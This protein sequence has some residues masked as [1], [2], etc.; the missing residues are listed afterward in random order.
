MKYDFTTVA[1]RRNIGAGKWEL[2]LEKNPNAAEGVIP[3]SV[4][5]MEFY[6]A[7]ELMNGLAKYAMQPIYGYTSP[8]DTYYNAVIDYMKKYHNWEIQ[9]EWICPT[10]GVVGALNDLVRTLTEPGDGVVIMRPVYYP[11]SSAITRNNR[12]LVNVPLINNNGRYEIDF[13]AFDQAT[14]PEEVKMFILCSPHN[15][16]GRVW[17]KDELRKMGDICVKNNIIIIS[18]EIHFDFIM[19]KHEHTVIST[20]SEEI[21]KRT[22]VCTAPSKTFNLG[23]VKVSNIIIQ[24]PEYREKYVA[25]THSLNTFAYKTCEIVYTECRNWFEELMEVLHENKKLVEDFI[26]EHLPMIKVYPLEGTY[27]MWLD[28]RALGLSN[29]EL[30]KLMLKHDL[31]LDEGYLFGEEGSGFERWNI[32]CPKQELLAGL[33]RFKAA[34]ETL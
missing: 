14:K 2:M 28:C 32:A 10:S 12:N 11:F 18:D 29:E 24:N 23:G 3:Y 33:E 26:A 22:V 25:V 6:N 7:P 21:A 13:E 4:A 31:Y 5:D 27:L 19:D 34:I 15:P 30:E 9:K 17:T 20:L 1:N 8:M 16:I